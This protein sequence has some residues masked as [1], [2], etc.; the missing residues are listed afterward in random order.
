[1]KSEMPGARSPRWVRRT[2]DG[3]NEV[4]KRSSSELGI[5]TTILKSRYNAVGRSL[6]RANHS[7]TA[8]ALSEPRRADDDVQRCP[9]APRRQYRLPPC[10]AHAPERYQK[11]FESGVRIC[12]EIVRC[13][14]VK[15]VEGEAADG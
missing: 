1:M 15:D 5:A 10:R 6:A 7:F 2:R 9:E 3:D 12:G 13:D 14:L 11:L 4:K 8:A